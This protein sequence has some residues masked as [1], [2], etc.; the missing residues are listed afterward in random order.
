M[1]PYCLILYLVG[2]YTA[3][4][5]TLPY[6]I[7]PCKA[8]EST[9]CVAQDAQLAEWA[10]EAWQRASR[11]RIELQSVTLPR[12]ARIRVY[13]ARPQPGQY[14]YAQPLLL[15]GKPGAEIY[16]RPD[17][18]SL[19]P[20]IAEEGR[21]DPL[22]RDSILYLTCLHEIGHALG[23]NHTAEFDDIMYNFTLGGDLR[24]YFLRYR[25]K[26]K[27]RNDIRRESGLS[28]HDVTRLNAIL[29]VQAPQPALQPQ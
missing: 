12:E 7:Q 6:W 17:L 8:T 14:G 19:G 4:G 3:C 26:L 24:E 11:G 22:F 25:R 23:L 28:R 5:E 15:D 16:V 29:S 2:V 21:K 10:L 27:T 1:K 13:W 18:D 9:G 20:E